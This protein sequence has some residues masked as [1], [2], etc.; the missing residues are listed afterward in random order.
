[1]NKINNKKYFKLNKKNLITL[2]I[3][4]KK[5]KKKYNHK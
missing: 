2:K 1:V 3:K 4:Y 5:I